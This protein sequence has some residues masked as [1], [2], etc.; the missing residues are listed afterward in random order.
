MDLR[1][2]L[3]VCGF[4]DAA[5]QNVFLEV[6]RLRRVADFGRFTE[7]DVDLM[8]KNMGKRD[9]NVEY[10]GS[11]GVTVG[12]VRSLHLRALRYWVCD[13]HRRARAIVP[14]DWTPAAMA[15]AALDRKIEQWHLG[16]PHQ[17]PPPP[18]LKFNERKWDVSIALFEMSLAAER[19]CD[20]VG[21]DYVVRGDDVPSHYVNQAQRLK[22]AVPLERGVHW[23]EDNSVV[24]AKIKR[25]TLDTPAWAWIRRHEAQADGRG[26]YRALFAHYIGIRIQWAKNQ[27]D[28]LVYRR[29]SDALPFETF[30]TKLMAAFATLAESPDEALAEGRKVDILLDKI[31]CP[32]NMK[33]EASKAMCRHMHGTDFDAA[34]RMM[35]DRVAVQNVAAAPAHGSSKRARRSN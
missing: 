32:N 7:S 11:G 6:E 24:W 1:A 4:V 20:G 14:A 15:A 29:E 18:P 35:S 5:E 27:I 3:A 17:S 2:V 22:Y 33:M 9:H 26:A 16:L 31:D 19:N 30:A 34:V 28:Q 8:I 12:V 23:R 25:W 13:N 10:C 21:L